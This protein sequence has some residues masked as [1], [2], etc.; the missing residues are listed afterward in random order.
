MASITPEP[1]TLGKADTTPQTPFCY[2][3]ERLIDSCHV[4]IHA[5]HRLRDMTALSDY[6]Q[7]HNKVTAPIIKLYEEFRVSP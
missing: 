3:L 1:Q 2:P 6:Q 7:R 4:P 5:R